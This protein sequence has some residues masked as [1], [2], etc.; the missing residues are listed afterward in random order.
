MAHTNRTLINATKQV[1]RS[2]WIAWSSI[3]VM[4]LAF[5]V[6]TIFAGIAYVAHLKIQSIETR[7]NVLV[8]FEVGTDPALISRLRDQ[9][10]QLPQ[11]KDIDYTTEE[12]A[13]EIY[14]QETAITDPIQNQLLA[15]QEIKK[16]DSSL[17]IKLHSLDYLPEVRRILLADINTELNKLSYDTKRPPI[18]LKVDDRSLDEQREIFLVVRI[19][20][21]VLL[22]LLFIIIFF[23]ILMTVEYRTYNR[24]E[25]I[26][27]MQ[28]VGG[29]LGYIRGPFILEGAFY[30][31]IGALISAVVL[32]GIALFM[33]VINA[34]SAIAIYIHEELR[35]LNMP[36]VSLLGWIGV[37]V[38]QVI[39]GGL[40]GAFISYLA[41]RRYIK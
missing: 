29:S 26:G 14:F 19:A 41:I 15:Q 8:F 6:G 18:D 2:G 23:F 25:E 11:I 10:K 1:S 38:L 21:L 20:G 30:G 12:K 36:Y 24:M 39:V 28:L 3:A 4:A 34:Q 32:G 7:D 40:L 9:W 13:Y 17:D 37:I 31:A 33:L 22:T 5:F 35:G 27:V 16:L